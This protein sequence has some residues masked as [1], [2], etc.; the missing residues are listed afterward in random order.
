MPGLNVLVPMVD[1]VRAKVDMREQVLDT[2]PQ[3]VITADN[4]MIQVDTV[5]YYRVLD[6]R[7]ATYQISDMRAALQHLTV[8]LL[9]NVIGAMDVTT[10][11]SSRDEINRAVQ[12]GTDQ[13]TAQWGVKV[14]RVEIKELEPP[15]S[16]REPLR[17]RISQLEREL[18]DLRR[19]VD[20][21]T[22]ERKVTG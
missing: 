6:P 11:L 3:P 14:T 22:G 4:L 5:L 2:T 21:A 13:N 16:V 17:H 12:A 9:R 10:T 19:A 8:T 7:A 18:A 1:R 20:E 15:P